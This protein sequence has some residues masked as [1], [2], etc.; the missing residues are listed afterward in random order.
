M[1]WIGRDETF[2]TPG[3]GFEASYARCFL[4]H[5][6]R[7]ASNPCCAGMLLASLGRWLWQQRIASFIG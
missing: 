2:I 7:F 5:G 3:I 4:E 1:E 6:G